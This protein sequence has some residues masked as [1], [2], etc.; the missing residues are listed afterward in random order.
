M[1]YI[2]HESQESTPEAKSTLY[3]LLANLT[4]NYILK[5]KKRTVSRIKKLLKGLSSR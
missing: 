2:S 3:T 4:I 5:K 1:L